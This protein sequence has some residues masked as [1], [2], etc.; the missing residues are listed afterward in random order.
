MLDDLADRDAAFKKLI[1][2][3]WRFLQKTAGQRGLR[4]LE[5]YQDLA[6]ATNEAATANAK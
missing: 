3:A 4:D 5:E 2:A 6:T 1:N